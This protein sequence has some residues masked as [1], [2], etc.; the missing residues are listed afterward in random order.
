[1][2]SFQFVDGGLIVTNNCAER[3]AINMTWKC[4]KAWPIRLSIE[5]ANFIQ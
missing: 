1:M 5:L 4:I 2:N 3:T